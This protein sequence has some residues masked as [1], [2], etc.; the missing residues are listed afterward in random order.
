[1]KLWTK[2]LDP[3]ATLDLLQ[4]G[5]S[6]SRKVLSAELSGDGSKVL[7]CTDGAEVWEL[8]AES[9]PP[10]EGEP[11]VDE[12]GNPVENTGPG[13]PTTAL[14]IICG[15]FGDALTQCCASPSA[16]E[17]ASIGSD[18]MHFLLDWE[19]FVH[20]WRQEPFASTPL[21]AMLLLE[22]TECQRPTRFKR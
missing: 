15:H 14:P 19:S 17:F 16:P 13:K 21:R 11:E 9:Q 18:G 12:E 20:F 10:G 22:C 1:M 3:I 8:T 5:A 7:V 2:S 4:V 6:L